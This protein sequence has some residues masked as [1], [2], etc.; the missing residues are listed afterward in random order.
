MVEQIPARYLNAEKIRSDIKND[1]QNSNWVYNAIHMDID[2][3]INSIEK[4]TSAEDILSCWF[5]IEMSRFILNDID[6]H[7]YP[8]GPS[9]K[10]NPRRGFQDEILMNP[11][12]PPRMAG[13]D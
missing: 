9:S 7:T 6:I 2:M 11:L 1:V 10:M 3:D 4:N 5:C 13:W 8:Y 12:Y